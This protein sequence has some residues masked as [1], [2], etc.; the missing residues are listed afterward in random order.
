M[1][2]HAT[3]PDPPPSAYPWTAQT[4]GAGQRV[5]CLQHAVQAHRVLDVRLVVEVDRRPLP[6]HVG[7]GAERRPLAR[8][9]D[10]ARV[11]DVRERVREL[12]D[13]RGVER[14]APLGARKRHVENLSVPLHSQRAHEPAA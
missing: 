10:R 6:F 5:D 7:A 1:S 2:A 13:E 11:A 4:T 8:E 9:D 14:V 3:R 12:C